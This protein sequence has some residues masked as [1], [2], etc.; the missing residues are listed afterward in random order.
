MTD[1]FPTAVYTLCF[2][3]SSACSFLLARNYGRTRSRLLLWS[4][5]C[6]LFLGL[7]NLAVIVD[8]LLIP[9]M[10]FNLLRVALSIAGVSLLL[11]GLVWEAE[12]NR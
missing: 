1:W 12:E 3:T 4:A 2:L 11:F 5:L 9:D 7:N 10:S 8:L 6:F